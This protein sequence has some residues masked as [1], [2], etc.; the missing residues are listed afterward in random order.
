M[1]AKREGAAMPEFDHRINDADN[2]F[3]EPPDRFER[4][5]DPKQADLAIRSVIAPDGVGAA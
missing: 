2:R 3:N 1:R 4:C 5:I